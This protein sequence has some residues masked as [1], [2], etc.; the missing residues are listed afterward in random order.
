MAIL[1]LF[2]NV[3][4]FVRGIWIIPILSLKGSDYTIACLYS[5][6]YRNSR[7]SCNSRLLE[8]INF[9]HWREIQDRDPWAKIPAADP[10]VSARPSYDPSGST[11]PVELVTLSGQY[12]PTASS[13]IPSASS[14]SPPPPRPNVQVE[15]S[16]SPQIS[17]KPLE[18]SSTEINVTSTYKPLE[19]LFIQQISTKKPLLDTYSY[20]STLRPPSSTSTV[21][22]TSAEFSSTPPDDSYSST[23]PISSTFSSFTSYIPAKEGPPVSAS[24][25]TSV[26]TISS[27][28]SPT[29]HH[30]SH[31]DNYSPHKDYASG[32]HITSH[33]E[34]N[35]QP[36]LDPYL[37]ENFQFLAHAIASNKSAHIVQ[38]DHRIHSYHWSI[39]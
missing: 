29:K 38:T 24:S 6:H 36:D 15:V 9:A 20:S 11:H 27:T 8:G 5:F 22:Y 12:K 4:P 17:Y 2:L 28:Y 3:F 7:V 13:F 1:F 33:I 14:Y 25:Y 32:T 35:K 31:K 23:R 16:Y 18:S 37:L 30:Y 39:E 10:W 21:S 34:I 26:N 19:S